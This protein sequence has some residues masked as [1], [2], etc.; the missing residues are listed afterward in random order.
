MDLN[1]NDPR[2]LRG[3]EV[4]AFGEFKE[5]KGGWRVSLPFGGEDGVFVTLDPDTCTCKQF[6][7][8][9]D[10]CPHTMGTR[11]RFGMDTGTGLLV[12][13]IAVLLRVIR[14][15]QQSNGKESPEENGHPMKTK[16]TVE[17]EYVTVKEACAIT[18]LSGGI[19]RR[20]ITT[21]KLL[22]MKTDSQERPTYRIHRPDLHAWMK[23]NRGATY[24]APR[25]GESKD[26][27]AHYFPGLRRK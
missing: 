4:A 15:S 5:T 19:I 22:A 12:G 20:A 13:I 8:N 11:M 17:R 27:V 18:G 7:C 14:Q 3:F 23:A 25:F 6:G 21:G 10:W 9:G 16:A 1:I 2:I 26:L 24:A